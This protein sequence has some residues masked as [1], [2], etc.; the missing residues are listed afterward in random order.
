MN[1][2]NVLDDRQSRI[3]KAIAAMQNF[4]GMVK[5]LE[6]KQLTGRELYLYNMLH[7]QKALNKAIELTKAI[8]E[9]L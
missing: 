4:K 2:T 1:N 3:D 8:D 6:K 9:K 7:M 5:V